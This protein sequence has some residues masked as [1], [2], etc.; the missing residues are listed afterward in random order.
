MHAFWSHV[1]RTVDTNVLIVVRHWQRGGGTCDNWG[2]KIE[3]FNK[4]DILWL[5]SK[6]KRFCPESLRSQCSACIC[7]CNVYFY[8]VREKQRLILHPAPYWWYVR[9]MAPISIDII[10]KLY[11]SAKLYR[12]VKEIS[13]KTGIKRDKVS[14][15]ATLFFVA[16]YSDK[17]FIVLCK[18]IEFAVL[19]ITREW[20]YC[21]YQL[22][23]E[24]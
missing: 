16:N 13:L 8:C 9:Q 6:R 20:R 7:R 21:S 10:V 3:H 5:S 17:K 22:E 23:R 2:D 11:T 14:S 1:A 15:F 18:W 12:N 4:S 24:T 19:L